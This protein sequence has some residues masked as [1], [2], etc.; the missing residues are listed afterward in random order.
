MAAN[1]DSEAGIALMKAAVMVSVM[2]SIVN[3]SAAPAQLFVTT[4]FLPLLDTVPAVDQVRF[5]ATE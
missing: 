2:A 1:A 3:G 5:Y 4:E